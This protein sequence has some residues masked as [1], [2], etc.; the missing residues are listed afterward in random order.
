LKSKDFALRG[1][2]SN[3]QFRVSTSD[4]FGTVSRLAVDGIWTLLDTGARLGR[5]LTPHP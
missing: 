1:P 2:H 3:T 4:D 5:D